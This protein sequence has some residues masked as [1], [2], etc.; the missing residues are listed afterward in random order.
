MAKHIL[1]LQAHPDPAA[2]HFGHALAQAY[3][4]GA[5]AAGHEV[6]TLE[7]A[8]L[9]FPW[10]K[11]RQEF[12]NGAPPEAIARAQDA[13]RQAGHLLIVFPLWLGT[14][15]ALSKAFLEQTLRP[16]YAFTPTPIGGMKKLLKGRTARIVV[17]M[18][19]PAVFYRWYFGAHGVRWLQRSVLGFCGIRTT[20][21]SLIG[22]V[23]GRARRRERWLAQLRELGRRAV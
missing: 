12:E 17:T 21:V 1:I 4:E 14:V 9:D 19:M 13:I 22:G 20:G 16:G 11:T 15:P 2:G 6:Q 23:E 3:A 8:R 7:I 10:L 18:G 5:R